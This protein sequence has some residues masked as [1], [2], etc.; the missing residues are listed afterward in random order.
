MT[1]FLIAL[2]GVVI[3]LAGFYAG[4]S[5]SAMNAAAHRRDVEDDPEP[6]ETVAPAEAKQTGTRVND[7]GELET[8]AIAGRQRRQPW[9]ERRRELEAKE[10]T[11]RKKIEQWRD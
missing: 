7:E 6:V 1:G 2:L 4:V 3:L 8:F 9:R 11:K 5:V 10:R